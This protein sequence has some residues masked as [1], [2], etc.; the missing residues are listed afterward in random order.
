MVMRKAESDSSTFVLK[1]E[2]DKP[3]T[4]AVSETVTYLPGPE[5][6]T[7]TKWMGQ[8][9]HANAPKIVTNPQLIDK[10]R[11]NRSFKV[12]PFDPAKDTVETVEPVPGPKTSDQ[13]RAHAVAWLKTMQSVDELDRKWA[14]EEVLRIDCEV[15]TDDIDLL[16]S[17]FD[18]K[19]S[20][21]RKREM[22]A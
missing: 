1:G 4:E 7:M 17:L 8:V 3:E 18:P 19:R 14:G 2:G 6:P 10:A 20:E 15:G 13:Y 16:R 22:A 5:G 9:F 21:L 12:G 11:A